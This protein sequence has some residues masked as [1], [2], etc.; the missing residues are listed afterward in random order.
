MQT[1][2]FSPARKLTALLLVAAASACFSAPAAELVLQDDQFL[3]AFNTDSGAL[4][5]LES[6]ATHW[7]IEQRPELAASFRLLVP[8]PDQRDN[9]VLGSKQRAAEVRKLSEHQ[10]RIRW[11]DLASEHGGV[12]PITLTATVTLTNGAL[13]FGATLQND[14]SLSVETVDYPCLGDLSPPSPNTS[15]Q[16]RTL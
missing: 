10:I 6:K 15:M 11:Q 16:A 14:S 3:A 13:V 5:R 12:L 7:R 2:A 4:T 1:Y 8:L 9:F